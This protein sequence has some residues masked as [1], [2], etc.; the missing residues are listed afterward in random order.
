[1]KQRVAVLGSTGS[2]GANTLDVIGRHPDRFEV[3]ALSGGSRVEPLLA[4]C[5]EFRPRVA[6]MADAGA[7]RELAGRVRAEGLPTRVLAGNCALDEVVAGEGVD[8][9]MAAIVGAAGLSSCLAAA[10]AGK[11]LLLANKEALV[12]GGELFL[13]AMSVVG[14]LVESLVKRSAGVK[15]SS[16]LLPGHGGVLDRVDALLPTLPLALMLTRLVS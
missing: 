6:V 16:G 7:A 5:A 4:Q 1:M 13:A 10:R 11:R 3:A 8:T 15:D 12:V 14:D 9:V 2:I